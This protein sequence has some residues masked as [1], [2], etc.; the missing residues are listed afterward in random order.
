MTLITYGNSEGERRCDAHCHDAKTPASACECIC[1]GKNHGV[2]LKKAQ[3]NTRELADTWMRDW[4]EKHP[5]HIINC[6][7]P[8]L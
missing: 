8:L 4:K 2:G 7:L 1:G 3:E 6:Q 5:D